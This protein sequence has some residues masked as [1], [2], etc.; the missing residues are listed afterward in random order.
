M[1]QTLIGRTVAILVADGFNEEEMCGPKLALEKAGAMTVLVSGSRGPFVHAASGGVDLPGTAYA[2]D[3]PISNLCAED[4]D[5][6]L[7]PG[8]AASVEGLRAEGEVG[9]VVREFAEQNKPIAAFGEAVSLLDDSENRAITA[10]DAG[11]ADALGQALIE[12]L[13]RTPPVTGDGADRDATPDRVA[14]AA[15]T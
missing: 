6:L 15:G 10:P 9:R 13:D 8:G 5:G 2:F 1:Q 4:Y 11:G 7:V 12:A 14:A 3:Q